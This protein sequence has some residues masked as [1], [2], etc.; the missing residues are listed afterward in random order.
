MKE[1]KK[2]KEV[3]YGNREPVLA[4]AAGASNAFNNSIAS[5]VGSRSEKPNQEVKPVVDAQKKT[6]D[7]LADIE[8]IYKKK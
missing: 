1:L 7:M 2:R 3:R 5:T 8:N 4:F 6:S